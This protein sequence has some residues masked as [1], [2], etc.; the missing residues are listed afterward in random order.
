MLSGL[1]ALPL[2][3]K[4]QTLLPTETDLADSNSQDKI[5]LTSDVKLEGTEKEI[6]DTVRNQF[7]FLRALAEKRGTVK[8]IGY[9]TNNKVSELKISIRKD[10]LVNYPYVRL[11]KTNGET[12]N[13]LW[14]ISGIYPSIKL[15]DNS[16]K[17]LKVNGKTMEFALKK[18]TSDKTPGD[19]L[20][21]GIKIL[22][23]ALLIWLGATIF[24]YVLAAIAFIAFNA[25]I[26]AV[27]IIGVSALITVIKW[28]FQRAGWNI[29]VVK[30][31]FNKSV[32]EII[33]LLLKVQN[34]VLAG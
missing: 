1:F 34:Y 16:G 26:L 33:E 5:Q 28:I 15:A 13:L 18:S 10:K 19:W 12:A 25:M 7:Q 9:R 31:Y 21:L 8:T 14:G 17:T 27:V 20:L 6:A 22:A 4:C 11:Q 3:N 2:F 30:S 32:D 23:A 29:D 24:K